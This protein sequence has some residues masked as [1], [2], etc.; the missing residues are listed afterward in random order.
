MENPP[1]VNV[2][3]SS[4]WQC[5]MELTTL[6]EFTLHP[7]LAAMLFDKEFGDCQA[8]P[9]S[10]AGLL[11]GSLST[12]KCFEDYFVFLVRNPNSRIHNGDMRKDL[13]GCR[14]E[15]N[16]SSRRRKFDGV[17]Q[18]VIEHLLN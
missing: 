7:D 16:T 15:A 2:I 14:R 4:T 10:L 12:V 17:A 5:E 6:V 8:E 18:Q 3:Y 13:L 11:C 9:G 1:I